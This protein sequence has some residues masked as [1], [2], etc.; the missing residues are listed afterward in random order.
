ME[1]GLGSLMEKTPLKVYLWLD[2]RDQDLEGGC[3]EDGRCHR[4]QKMRST[5]VGNPDDKMF[6]Y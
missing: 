3:H 5:F 4:L 6:A 2:V 1:L